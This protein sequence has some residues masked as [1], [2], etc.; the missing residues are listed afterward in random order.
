MRFPFYSDGIMTYQTCM[1][2]TT[3][4]DAKTFI[5]GDREEMARRFRSVIETEGPI[6][7]DLLQKRVLHSYGLA[8]RGN[9][10]QPV[11]DEVMDSLHAKATIQISADGKEHRVFWPDSM[12][13]ASFHD[14]R[15]PSGRD[16]TEIPVV[17]IA[18]L[19]ESLGVRPKQKLFDACAKELGFKKKGSNI[20]KTFA[21]AYRL[22]RSAKSHVDR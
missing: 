7:D 14:C 3:A 22:S 15:I 9:R 8:K 18:N 10:I 12:E 11:L 21:L 16:I 2:E 13:A 4:M 5:A 20:R 17:E 19:M 1:L 6:V